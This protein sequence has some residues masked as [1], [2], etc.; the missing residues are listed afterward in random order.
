MAK[1]EDILVDGIGSVAVTGGV[2]R[3]ELQQLASLAQASESPQMQTAA[4]LAFS[5]DTLLKFNQAVSALLANL[6]SRGVLTKTAADKVSDED[7]K[8]GTKVSK[9]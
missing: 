4:R 5:I 7:K 8:A 6:E 2:V 3:I 1:V 9:Q